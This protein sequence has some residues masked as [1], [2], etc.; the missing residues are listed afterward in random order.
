MSVKR[1]RNTV[2]VKRWMPFGNH[3]SAMAGNRAN[4]RVALASRTNAPK[5]PDGGA[6]LNS[7]TAGRFV[8]DTNDV[9]HDL[10]LL[11][12]RSN[13]LPAWGSV[14]STLPKAKPSNLDNE[15]HEEGE[16]IE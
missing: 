8:A 9:L 13:Y 1:N 2:V 11:K 7:A 14:Y 3:C 5:N 16:C 6:R 10:S 15:N 4:H 12:K